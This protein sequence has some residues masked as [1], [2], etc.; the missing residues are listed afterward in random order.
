MNIEIRQVKVT[1]ECNDTDDQQGLR[2]HERTT[3]NQIIWAASKRRTDSENILAANS[4]D[5]A[6]SAGTRVSVTRAAS[7]ANLCSKEF[8]LSCESSEENELNIHFALQS[9]PSHESSRMVG[10]CF[11]RRSR[12]RLLSSICSG[13]RR[14]SLLTSPPGKTNAMRSVHLRLDR[15]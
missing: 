11:R 8:V 15:G 1:W 14:C 12:R 6:L 4:T 9:C 10:N 3:H 5:V 13:S 7:T 2:N